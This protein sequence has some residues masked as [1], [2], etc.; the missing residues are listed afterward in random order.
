MPSI[1]MPETGPL[2]TPAAPINDALAD[3]ATPRPA[4]EAD[5]VEPTRATDAAAPAAEN[6]AG[7]A[8]ASAEGAEPAT[9]PGAPAIPTLSPAECAQRLKA[10]FPALF[11][12]APKPLK[13][14]IQTDIQQRAPGLFTRRALSAFLHRYTGSTGYLLAIT[15]LG[16]RHDLDGVA[17][18]PISE[19]HRAVAATELAR[20]RGNQDER[21]AVEDE[22]RALEETQHRNRAGLLR[23]HETTT[24]TRANFCVL[25]GVDPDALDDLLVRAR[26]EREEMAQQRPPAFDRPRPPS[27]RPGGVAQHDAR[28]P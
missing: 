6:D 13:L 8:A 21:R 20:R 2:L 14:R 17:V 25:K 27:G 22:H 15:R 4:V 1:P 9:A 24:L 23:D 26:S 3:A 11:A 5:L 18:E 28:D 16:Q 19:E 7:V 10:L 12:G